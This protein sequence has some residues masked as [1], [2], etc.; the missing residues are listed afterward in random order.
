MVA[1]CR[2]VVSGLKRGHKMKIDRTTKF[3]SVAIGLG[4]FLSAAAELL[5]PVPAAAQFG[6]TRTIKDHLRYIE[7]YLED[8][9][10]GTCTNREICG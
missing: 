2:S 9:H 7:M 3:L 10:R 5:R 4:L 8:I 1:G 6:R